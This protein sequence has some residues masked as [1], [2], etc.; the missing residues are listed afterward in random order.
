MAYIP[1]GKVADADDADTYH[2]PAFLWAHPRWMEIKRRELVWA[3]HLAELDYPDPKPIHIL[4]GV[5]LAWALGS[6]ATGYDAKEIVVLKLLAVSL[7]GVGLWTLL[8]RFSRSVR[9]RN[10]KPS[11]RSAG[12]S[13]P[14]QLERLGRPPEARS[15]G[16]DAPAV[17]SPLGPSSPR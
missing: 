2:L 4:L 7:G 16:S 9:Y 8:M 5:V 6:I 3:K 10:G 1:R 13:E 14:E 17:G 11:T 12:P 15:G